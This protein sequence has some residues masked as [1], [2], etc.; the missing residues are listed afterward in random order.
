ML[1]MRCCVHQAEIWPFLANI[2]E[3]LW[4]WHDW[5][6][7][8]RFMSAL[9]A[10]GCVHHLLSTVF[11]RTITSPEPFTLNLKW[12]PGDAQE[13]VFSHWDVQ[14]QARTTSRSLQSTE[15]QNNFKTCWTL[16]MVLPRGE[17]LGTSWTDSRERLSRRSGLLLKPDWHRSQETSP[18]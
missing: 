17:D 14:V 8:T 4:T 12:D 3:N 10:L 9:R 11:A 5:V 6:F 13:C 15:P 1:N 18:L 2:P 7:S 16:S